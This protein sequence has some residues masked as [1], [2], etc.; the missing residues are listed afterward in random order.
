[1]VLCDL[2]TFG[3]EG[4]TDLPGEMRDHCMFNTGVIAR[5]FIPGVLKTAEGLCVTPARRRA[6]PLWPSLAQTDYSGLTSGSTIG[7]G[8]PA[9]TAIQ[10]MAASGP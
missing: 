6:P 2:I 8:V 3:V 5:Q 9:C 1:V 4:A 10:P 7:G